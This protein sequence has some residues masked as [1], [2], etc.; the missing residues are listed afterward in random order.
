MSRHFPSIHFRKLS[1]RWL[2]LVLI[3]IG[4]KIVRF[5]F[6]QSDVKDGC[7]E[8]KTEDSGELY[9]EKSIRFY[10]KTNEAQKRGGSIYKDQGNDTI[11]CIKS[12]G[13]VLPMRGV[14]D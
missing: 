2:I 7:P 4:S 3:D 13:M 9:Y 14:L 10:W 5:D 12:R 1:K 11:L 8:N 6:N